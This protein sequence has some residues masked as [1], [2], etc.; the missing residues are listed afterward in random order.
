MEP[1]RSALCFGMDELGGHLASIPESSDVPLCTDCQSEHW[2]QEPCAQ[3]GTSRMHAAAYE[4]ARK[5]HVLDPGMA[6]LIVDS[7]AL[8]VQRGDAESLVAARKLLRLF[9]S[10]RDAEEIVRALSEVYR[11]DGAWELAS[12]AP[13]PAWKRP[14]GRIENSTG[15][16]TPPAV[17]ELPA[18]M[19]TPA[20][21]H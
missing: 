16:D 1:V 15:V 6:V 18:A 21:D 17:P 13:E 20:D 5:Y 8:W 4:I 12:I 7:A 11:R 3:M 14:S 10:A 9:A 19:N 2:A